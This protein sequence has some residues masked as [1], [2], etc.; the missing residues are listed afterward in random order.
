MR[1]GAR[2]LL[3]GGPPGSWSHRKPGNNQQIKSDLSPA[4]PRKS[5]RRYLLSPWTPTL[6]LMTTQQSFL[7]ACSATSDCA[8]SFLLDPSA[9]DRVLRFRMGRKSE[10][11]R[12]WSNPRWVVKRSSAELRSST[13]GELP[14]SGGWS[15]FGLKLVVVARRRRRGGALQSP[16]LTGVKSASF[17]A[18]AWAVLPNAQPTSSVAASKIFFATPV[19]RAAVGTTRRTRTAAAGI[20]RRTDDARA[21]S[22][23]RPFLASPWRRVSHDGSVAVPIPSSCRH[24][25][26]PFDGRQMAVALD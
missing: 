15:K 14:S 1:G 18:W 19:T 25:F 10:I 11:S 4:E 24:L 13:P 22:S 26:H 2:H 5:Q 9:M 3:Q 20:V 17:R 16:H 12:R 23:G 6:P 21:S 8:R 7:D